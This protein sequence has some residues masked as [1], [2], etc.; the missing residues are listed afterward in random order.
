MDKTDIPGT[1]NA[2]A[3]LG[4]VNP[5]RSKTSKM[6][7]DVQAHRTSN[8]VNET[9]MARIWNHSTKLMTGKHKTITPLKRKVFVG[10]SGGVDSSVAAALLKKQEFDVTGVFIKIWNPKWGQC[11]EKD[12]RISAMRVCAVLDIPFREIDLS[13]EYEKDVVSNMVAEY[14][15]GRTPNPDVLCNRK[16]KFGRFFDWAIKNGADYIATGHYAKIIVGNTL[17][18]E[19]YN[20][21]NCK[22]KI[23]V[24]AAKDQTYFLWTLTQRELQKTFFPIGGYTKPRVRQLA[25]KFKL[26]TYDKKD[27]QGLCFLGKVDIKEFLSKYIAPKTGDVLDEQGAIIGTHEGAFNFTLGQRHGFKITVKKGAGE[28]SRHYVVLR[29]V[30]NNTVTV[31][32]KNIIEGSQRIG[33]RNFV[34]KDTNWIGGAAPKSGKKYLCRIRHTGDLH[35]CFLGINEGGKV[36]LQ[37][38]KDQKFVASG[39]SAVVYDRDVCLGGGIVCEYKGKV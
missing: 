23:P 33:S 6:S 22:L 26:P 35:P 9:N 24:D 16:I 4:P 13:K 19:N 27:S 38:V 30:G 14:Q 3:T 10:V 11:E 20:I 12:E 39:Q 8:G 18:S 28:T 32:R 34:L 31:A 36:L 17:S 5:V 15:V 37:F 29:D 1:F 2:G 7:A 25:K 21:E